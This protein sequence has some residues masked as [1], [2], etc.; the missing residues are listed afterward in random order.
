M[1]TRRSLS[2][3]Q[4]NGKDLF[5]SSYLK[6]TFFASELMH[7]LSFHIGPISYLDDVPFKVNEKFRCPAKVGLPVGFCLPDCTSL[8]VDS[9]VFCHSSHFQTASLV[10][11]CDDRASVY[12]PVPFK[13]NMLMCCFTQLLRLPALR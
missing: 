4:N 10:N 7:I 1:A 9:Q 11:W 3:A 6:T 12:L 5:N 13:Q 8:L 2:D